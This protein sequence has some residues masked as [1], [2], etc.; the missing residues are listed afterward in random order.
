MNILFL[1]KSIAL[2]L[3]IK[4]MTESVPSHLFSQK[5]NGF[6]W[7]VL[8]NSDLTYIAIESRN[9]ET[10]LVTFSALS[11][12]SGDFLFREIKMEEDWNLSLA[13][14]ATSNLI[15]TAFDQSLIPESK[16]IISLHIN[17]GSVNWQRYNLSLNYADD[18][19]LMVFDSKIQPRKYYRI[20]PGT[21]EIL[22]EANEIRDTENRL[23]FPE[24]LSSYK[25]PDWIDEQMINGS[26]SALKY[27]DLEMVSFHQ[28]ASGSLEQR[29]LVYQGDKVFI[30]DIL[31]SGIQKLQP[32]S[33]FI[34]N[35]HLFYIRNKSEII[36]YLV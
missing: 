4:I 20:D 6:I 7:K 34:C 35:K 15:I 13:F 12:E 5:I 24:I 19:G 22:T 2:F 36:S 8:I 11:L 3:L 31:I 16:G 26:I 30:D 17:D 33:F 25:L 29:L 14:A 32:E 1:I 27:H 21:G 28:K 9:S 10:K 23:I 18:Q